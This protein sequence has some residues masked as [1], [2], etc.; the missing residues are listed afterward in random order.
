[1]GR[2]HT[3]CPGPVGG[4]DRQGMSLQESPALGIW[5]LKGRGGVSEPVDLSLR[6]QNGI[7]PC[8]WVN[9]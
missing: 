9:T 3:P 4:T 7:N 6:D 8:P 1:M 2:R 5:Q